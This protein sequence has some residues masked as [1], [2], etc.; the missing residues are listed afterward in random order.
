MRHWI[1]PIM[2]VLRGR[3]TLTGIPTWQVSVLT[4]TMPETMLPA[5]IQVAETPW[6]L[7]QLRET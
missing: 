7:G 1:P 5:I 6:P 2:E 3:L 4:T